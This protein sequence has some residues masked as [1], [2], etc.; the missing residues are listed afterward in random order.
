[1]K[2]IQFFKNLF[3]CKKKQV[4]V[5]KETKPEVKQEVKQEVK[6]EP[7]VVAPT[8]PKPKAPKTPKKPTKPKFAED[9][10]HVE[11]IPKP[12]DVTPEPIEPEEPTEPVDPPKFK[13]DKPE[14]KA[15]KKK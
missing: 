6:D 7:A 13:E 2:I 5:V 14:I 15:N 8:K 4:V 3:T 12:V 10:G 9:T 11:L 1:M